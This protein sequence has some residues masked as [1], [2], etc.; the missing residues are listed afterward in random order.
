MITKMHMVS[1]LNSCKEKIGDIRTSATW[2]NLVLEMLKVNTALSY[3]REDKEA[4][5]ATTH[6]PSLLLKIDF[7]AYRPEAR[8][9]VFF[10]TLQ[11]AR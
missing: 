4:N 8:T 5:P 11:D 3:C 6:F 10:P 7:L 1:V 9:L 2:Q